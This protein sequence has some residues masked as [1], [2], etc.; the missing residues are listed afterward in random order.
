MQQPTSASMNFI[1]NG[2][3]N[4]GN[5]GKNTNQQCKI[6]MYKKTIMVCKKTQ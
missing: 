5:N 1:S 3:N 6:I 4:Y 2:N